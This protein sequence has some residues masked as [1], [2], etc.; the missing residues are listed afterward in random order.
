MENRRL[1]L[2]QKL[3][4]LLGNNH[5]YYQPPENIKLEYPAIVYSKNRINNRFA[6][7]LVYKQNLTYQIIVIDYVPDSLITEKLSTI[8]NCEYQNSYVTDGLNHDVFNFYV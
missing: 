3:I 1:K 8:T 5:V 6:D 2:H 4:E 7:N